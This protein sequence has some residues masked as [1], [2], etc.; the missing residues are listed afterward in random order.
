MAEVNMDGS[1]GVPLVALGTTN[2]RVLEFH[3]RLVLDLVCERL[4][5]LRSTPL[6]D[7]DRLPA[8]E[9]VRRGFCDPIRLFVKNEPHA[10]SKARVGRWRLIMSVSLLDQLV[11][12]VLCSEM[13]KAEIANFDSLPVKPGMG[14][15]DEQ[16]NAIGD[17]LGD[18]EVPT[19]SDVSGWDWSVTGE[20]LRWD[21]LRRAISSGADSKS[22][23]TRMLL[24]R[25]V[26]L[27]RSVISF[28]D[29]TMVAQRFDGLQK[30]GSYNTSS[31]NSWIRCASA[32]L[33]GAKDVMAM[34]DDCVDDRGDP[35]I[36]SRL[37]HVVKESSVASEDIPEWKEIL[38]LSCGRETELC[39]RIL[40]FCGYREFEPEARIVANF[41]SHLWFAHRGRWFVVYLGWR[42]SLF[43]LQHQ[44]IDRISRLC[45]FVS[46]MDR[47]PCLPTVLTSL[48][49][50]GWLGDDATYFDSS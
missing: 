21:A 24:N 47:N 22:E 18:M 7:V 27:G 45:E 41:C 15:S 44:K 9:L 28:S 1:P 34:G 2:S 40:N 12:R 23:Y 33:S 8:E 6:E 43:R 35:A 37:G 48:L 46:L 10:D 42:K 50:S 14:F 39:R 29:G 32:W 30:S 25:S 36:V 49:S 3:R 16:V 11:E 17:H 5:L 20:E 31:G 13:N 38:S 26:C 19:S 4:V